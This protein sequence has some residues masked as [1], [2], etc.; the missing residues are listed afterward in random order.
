M[1]HKY[2]TKWVKSATKS[3]VHCTVM[4]STVNMVKTDTYSYTAQ[5]SKYSILTLKQ[6]QVRLEQAIYCTLID[7]FGKNSCLQ[8]RRHAGRSNYGKDTCKAQIKPSSYYKTGTYKA[9]EEILFTQLLRCWIEWN[10]KI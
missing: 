4:Y 9:H 10:T 7:K 8:G 1:L 3:T 2:V 6:E 5:R